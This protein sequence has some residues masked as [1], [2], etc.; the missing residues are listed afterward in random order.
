M[1]TKHEARTTKTKDFKIF[2]TWY[3]FLFILTQSN[4]TFTSTNSP[5][6]LKIYD[7]LYLLVFLPLLSKFYKD[8]RCLFN[9]YFVNRIFIVVI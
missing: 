5:S 8:F 6:S 7:P 4:F 2:R 1:R 3:I 9:V